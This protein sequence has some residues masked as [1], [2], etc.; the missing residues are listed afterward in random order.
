MK[1]NGMKCLIIRIDTV[2]GFVE[3]ATRFICVA[4]G[5]SM[6]AVVIC[7]VIARYIMKNPIVWT[8]EIGRALMIWTAFLGVSI[9]ARHR[10]HP[11][12]TLLMVRLSM[13][14]QRSVKLF[15]DALTMGFLYVLT[16]YGIRMV[17]TGT[18]QIETSTGISM[19]Y[20]FI[21]IPLCGLLT[22]IQIGV[23]ML[24][25]LSRWGT[26]ISPYN[27]GESMSASFNS[28]T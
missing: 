1:P 28:H 23:I 10:S 6:A 5:G 27:K 11:G 16:A 18:T 26:P 15:T 25:D 17:E 12:V 22:M 2:A 7:G 9:A 4:L 3:K 20:F 13:P 19:S 21:C 8:E 24:L 14:L